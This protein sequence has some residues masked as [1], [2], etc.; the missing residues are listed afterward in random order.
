M[1]KK[2]FFMFQGIKKYFFQNFFYFILFEKDDL[3]HFLF[4]AVERGSQRV[5]ESE[6]E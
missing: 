6:M 3:E 1:L 2:F 4:D 5:R